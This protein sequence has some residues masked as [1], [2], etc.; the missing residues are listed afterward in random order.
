MTIRLHQNTE[1]ERLARKACWM[2]TCYV[3]TPK[4]GM[5]KCFGHGLSENSAIGSLVKNIM[6]P[7]R[8]VKDKVKP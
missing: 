6:V 7:I 8:V 2:A 1:A 3:P 5:I 4:G